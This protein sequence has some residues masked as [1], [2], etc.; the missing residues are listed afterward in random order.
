MAARMGVGCFGGG[1]FDG[2]VDRPGLKTRHRRRLLRAEHGYAGFNVVCFVWHAAGAG[3]IDVYSLLFDDVD[4]PA[5][6]GGCSTRG[7]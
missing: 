7:V 2:I 4:R 1:R 5:I 6:R 3:R